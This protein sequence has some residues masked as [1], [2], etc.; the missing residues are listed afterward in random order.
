[1]NAHFTT[2]SLPPAGSSNTQSWTWILREVFISILQPVFPNFTI[3]RTDQVA[4]IP[5]QIPILGVYLLP[6]K[7]THDGDWN[8]GDIRFIHDFQVGFQ[9]MIANNSEQVVEQQLDSCYWLIMNSLW[10][11]RAAA[12]FFNN[13]NPDQAAMEGVIAG[14]RSYHYGTLSNETPV[15]ELRY[16]ATCRYRTYDWAPVITDDLFKI[17]EN[18]VPGG[19]DPTQTQNIVV[20]YGFSSTG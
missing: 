14:V 20:E 15:A 10:R 19:F 11:N 13:L 1:M 6:E 8:V 9:V 7:M 12:S 5:N 4:I 18:I 2:V 17:V 16:D 3:R